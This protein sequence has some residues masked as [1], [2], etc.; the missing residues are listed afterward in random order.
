MCG[1]IIIC[2]TST[3]YVSVNE[4]NKLQTDIMHYIDWWAREEKTPIPQKQIIIHMKEEGVKDFTTI[5]AVNSLLHKGYIR[6]AYT[7]SNKTFYV[8]IRKV[9]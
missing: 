8:M 4:I 9:T 3:V 1:T 6:R 7:I 5:N 2:M